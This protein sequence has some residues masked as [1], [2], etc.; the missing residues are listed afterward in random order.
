MPKGLKQVTY[1]EWW[2]SDLS[3]FVA[4]FY[5]RP[6][7]LQQQNGCYTQDS[8]LKVTVDGE[9]HLDATL[10]DQ[11]WATENY[12]VAEAEEILTA[13]QAL[14]TIDPADWMAVMD[15]ERDEDAVNVDLILWDLCRKNVIPAGEYLI[16]VWW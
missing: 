1:Y 6:W 5:G 2:E 9:S 16:T 13:W 15:A 10:S 12:T 4:D 11:P 14:P 8:Y 7:R 3:Q